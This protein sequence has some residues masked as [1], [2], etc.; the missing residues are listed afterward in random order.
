[1]GLGGMNMQNKL[2][3]CPFCGGEAEMTWQ[4]H[5]FDTML[6]WIFCRECGCKQ[7]SSIHKEAVINAWNTRKPMERIVEGLEEERKYSFEYFREDEGQF[8]KGLR[9]A[10]RIIKKAGGTDGQ[11]N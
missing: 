9:E 5:G 4:R 8:R 3:P 11:T 1:M 6:Y 2:L 7:C 10:I